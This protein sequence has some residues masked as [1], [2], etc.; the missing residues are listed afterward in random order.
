MKH[1]LQLALITV[2]S[3][4]VFS[5]CDNFEVS[6][7]NPDVAL[8]IDNNP[9]LL[10]TGIERD[11]INRMV[12]AAWSEGNLMGQYGARIVFTSFDLF[13]WG[14]QSGVWD[15]LYLSIRDAKKLEEIARDNET[16]SYEAVSLILQAWMFQILTDMWG[17]VPFTQVAQADAEM[18]IYTPAFDFQGD[19]YAGLLEQLKTAN[20]LLSS[21]NLPSIKGD[22]LYDG[23][24]ERWRKFAN[25]LRLRVALR[26]SEVEPGTARSHIAEIFNNPAQYPIMESNA[27]NAALL[28]LPSFPNAHP[29][30]ETN[31]YRVGSY[32]EYRIAETLVGILRDYNDPRL[33][34]WADPTANSVE[35][36]QP[37]IEGMQNGIVDGPA[38]EYK[39]GD[40]FLSKFNIDFFH[41]TPNANEGR[42][43]QY[44]EVA[45]IL[46][47]AAQRDWIDADAGEWY[48][49]GVQASF[50]YWNVT[51]PADYLNDVAAYDGTLERIMD[52]KYLALFY[53]DYQGFIE[54]RRTG[55]PEDIQPGPD[56][57]YSTYPSRFEYPSKEQALNA[58][59]RQVAIDRQGP[60]EIT[61]PV[62]WEN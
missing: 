20:D 62:W 57:F 12:G 51:M 41:F 17:D 2:L 34:F 3:L 61:T 28:F 55:F 27:D 16:P 26:L 58:T 47:E 21:D 31:R 50:E 14:D 23:D 44:A 24:L 5:G 37:R 13:D 40:A 52:Q 4:A 45:L 42:L 54:F 25:S 60:D 18:P 36:G 39:G 43:M 9:E 7:E 48:D 6:N 49:K 1:I 10:L 35:Q 11:A 46:A 19:I 30:S 32:N 29:I 38:Y 8:S 22:I 33:E 59:S 53:T 15:R 56:A